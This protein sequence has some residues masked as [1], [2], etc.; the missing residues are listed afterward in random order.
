MA[1]NDEVGYKKPPKHSRFRK[2]ASGNPSGRPQG[3][4]NIASVVRRTL[5]EEV[6]IN[7]NGKRSTI[8]KL[9]A[10][11]K[12]LINQAAGGNLRA[13]SQATALTCAVED[14]LAHRSKSENHRS[15]SDTDQK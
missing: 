14:M 15:S 5:L 11:V 3:T 2:G 7:E 1:D 4:L 6:V 13:L 12:Q 9:E 10:L 8:T